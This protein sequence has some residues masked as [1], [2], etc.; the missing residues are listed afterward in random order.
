MVT[1]IFFY[2]SLRD[3]GLLEIV[4]GRAVDPAHLEPARV[5][6]HAA[7]RIAGETYPVLLPAP[8]AVAS[9]VVFHHPSAADLARLAYFEE[10][11]YRLA[12]I[13]V[14]TASGPRDAL[15]FKGTEKP[16]ALTEPW[17]FDA[18]RDAHLAVTVETVREYM[19]HAGTLPVEEVDTI[20][21]GIKIRAHQRARALAQAPRLGALRTGFAPGDVSIDELTR[22]YTNFLAVQELRLRHRRFDGGWTSGID[23][24]VVL[25]GDAVTLLPYDP[26]RDRVLLIEQFR[27][28]PAARGDRNPWCIEVVAGRIDRAESAEDTARREAREEAGIEIGRI[29]E[30][31]GYYATPG[32][33][34]E[35]LT[36]FIGEADL[37]HAGGLHGLADEHEDI[38]AIVLDFDQA[39]AAVA[40]GA[41]N[42][43]PALVA[44]LWLAANRDR[45]RRDWAGE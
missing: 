19:H 23:R 21:T 39:M 5:A 1:P 17:D 24:S 34:A 31:G 41:V 44:L 11:E 36:G 28:G 4:L 22:A 18:W 16:S 15:F 2:G 9:G 6:G 42:T 32:L 29:A 10:V 26:R 35:H 8:G 30:A 43:G 45:L 7:R 40:D 14:E 38:R 37:P 33:A 20:W 27:P 25:W 13:T 12:P 3:P